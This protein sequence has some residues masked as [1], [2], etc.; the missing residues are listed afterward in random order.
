VFLC[1]VVCVIDVLQL[2]EVCVIVLDMRVGAVGRESL[3]WLGIRRGGG[4]M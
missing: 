1:G 3:V 2:H 4:S